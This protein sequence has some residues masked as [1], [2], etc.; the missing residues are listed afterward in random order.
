MAQELVVEKEELKK[1]TLETK[2]ESEVKEEPKPKEDLISRVSKVAVAPKKEE[3]N[4]FGLTKEDYDAVQKDQ[5]LS[6]FYKSMLA[7][8]TRKTQNLSERERELEKLSNW[9]PERVQQLLNDQKFVQAAQQVAS[10]QNPPNSGLTDQ[11]YS[12]L[13]DKEKAQLNQ[14]QQEMHQLKLQNWQMLQKQQDEQLRTKYANYAPDIVDVTI[15]K[16]VKG[17]VQATRETVWKA[18]DYEDAVRRAY[19]LGKQDRALENQE[20]EQSVS[21]EGFS[22]TPKQEVPKAEPN[23][24]NMS[25]FKRLAA[26]RL[27]EFK[28]LNK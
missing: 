1:E 17:E 28:G 23:E 12:A 18:L 26:K 24:S 25:Y 9:T 10:I 13:T 2:A 6:K 5:T 20:K 22:A 15:H 3:T 14:M 21:I 11:E 4:P 16:L 8:Y 27:A 19:E 7:D